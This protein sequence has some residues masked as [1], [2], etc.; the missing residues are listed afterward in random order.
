MPRIHIHGQ[1]G[2]KGKKEQKMATGE[3]YA[4]MREGL[5]RLIAVSLS[6]HA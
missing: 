3:K 5:L 4:I 1:W 2:R 6:E